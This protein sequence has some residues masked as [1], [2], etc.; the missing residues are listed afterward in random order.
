MKVAYFTGLRK[1]EIREEPAPSLS[2]AG[3]E[4]RCAAGS[5][6]VQIDRVGV[7]G[8]D[9]HY[10]LR[11]RI[12]DQTVEY[13]ATLGHECAGTVAQLGSQVKSLAVGDRVAID[14]A[15]SCGH[16][17]QCRIGRVNTCRNLQFLGCPGEAP[18]AVAEYRVLPAENC[19][20][21][22]DNVTLEEAVLVE[23]L[24]I[25]LYAARLGEAEPG[26]RIAVLGAGPIGLS[27]LLCLKA[28]APCTVYVTDLID[29]RLEIARRCG[30][31][32]TG[33]AERDDVTGAISAAEATGLDLVFE[34]SGDPACI[35]QAQRMLTP[36]GTLVLVGIPSAAEVSFDVHRMRRTEL[37]FKNVRRQKGCVEAVIRMIAER[38]IDVAPLLTHS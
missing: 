21:I 16:C 8:S 38:Q 28:L 5:V 12:G 37:T 34:C 7:C 33:N 15:L 24:S 13:P 14:P 35:D 23:P 9:V 6:V 31:D 19:L 11:G 30:A 26:A 4:G 22:P 10:Y 2:A 20:R 25:G 32:W 1:L 18:G 29:R 3:S 36:G 17:D 27:V